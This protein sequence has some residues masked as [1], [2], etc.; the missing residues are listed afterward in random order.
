MNLLH[1]SLQINCSPHISSP[2]VIPLLNKWIWYMHLTVPTWIFN[3]LKGRLSPAK[4]KTKSTPKESSMLQ[5]SLLRYVHMRQNNLYASLIIFLIGMRRIANAKSKCREV[6][7]AYDL[8]KHI[9]C[10]SVFNITSKLVSR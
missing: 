3:S 1:K 10:S 2:E 5:M 8:Y 4:Q 7:L 9:C 6:C